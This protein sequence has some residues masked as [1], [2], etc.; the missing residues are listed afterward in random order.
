MKYT[1][2]TIAAFAS[3]AL[4]KPA[5]LNTDFSLT[6][7]TPYTI[8]YSGCDDGCTIVLQNGP[9]GDLKDYKT[10]TAS[11]DGDSFTF[12]PSGL[13]TDTYNFKITDKAGEIN[14]SS[15]FEIEGSYAAP[16]VTKSA[17]ATATAPATTAVASTTLASVTKP[18]TTV[19]ESTTTVAKP[20]IPTHA[21]HGN[22]TVTPI[23]TPSKTGGAGGATGVPSVP[24]SG[25]ARMTSSLAL[26]AGAVMAMVYLN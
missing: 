5:F 18:A 10:L 3:V 8:R 25:A 4:A 22:A 14:Y 21:P 19:E 11:A 6:E 7:G 9:S 2:A 26:I 24:E 23:A 15:Q 12:T 1:I 17:T 16:S 13:P 20:I